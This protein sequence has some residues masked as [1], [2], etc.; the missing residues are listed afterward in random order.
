MIVSEARP[1]YH[2]TRRIKR[3]RLGR[4]EVCHKKTTPKKFDV[5]S[6]ED[7]REGRVVDS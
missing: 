5:T 1:S 7:Y 6:F 3:D 2:R 4:E